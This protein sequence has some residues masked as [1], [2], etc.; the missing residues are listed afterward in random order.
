MS[1]RWWAGRTGD[2][3]TT[4]QGREQRVPRERGCSRRRGEAG[5]D[6]TGEPH[7]NKEIHE[8]WHKSFTKGL[9]L[10]TSQKDFP[11]CCSSNEFHCVLKIGFTPNFSATRKSRLVNLLKRSATSNICRL[12][13][14]WCQREREGG[15]GGDDSS[16]W[17]LGP[18]TA[19]RSVLPVTLPRPHGTGRGCRGEGEGTRAGAGPGPSL[20]RA[21]FLLP[22]LRE[23]RVFRAA[24]TAS[25]VGNSSRAPP[26]CT[27][28]S[29]LTQGSFLE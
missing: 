10:F 16:A 21:P 8:H 29:G 11:K 24:R 26:T 17:S 5:E 22:F 1:R 9:L 13:C 4:A 7:P 15:P 20:P 2:G 6:L 18:G 25:L 14:C 3:E 19:T 27:Q 28:H 23:E 12:L